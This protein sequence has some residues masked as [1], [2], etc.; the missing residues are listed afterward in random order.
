MGSAAKHKQIP[1]LINVLVTL[2]KKS[3][4]EY[5]ARINITEKG[6]EQARIFMANS[7]SNIPFFPASD[8]RSSSLIAAMCA[9]GQKLQALC[10]NTTIKRT[11][12]GSWTGNTS[13]RMLLKRKAIPDRKN[14]KD[15]ITL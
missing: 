6:S 10:G 14:T 4:E 11:I 5:T 7:R 12:A 1:A 15:K 9:N 3:P 8:L 13:R 2:I